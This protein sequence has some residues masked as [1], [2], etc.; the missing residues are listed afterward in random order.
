MH[1]VIQIR[2]SYKMCQRNRYSSSRSVQYLFAGEICFVKF[3]YPKYLMEAK[4]SGDE[5]LKLG[6]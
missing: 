2:S 4:I 5:H 6:V 3:L 1:A